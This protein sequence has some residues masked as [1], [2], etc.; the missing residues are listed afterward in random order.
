MVRSMRYLLLDQ[1]E[2][3][4]AESKGPPFQTTKDGATCLLSLNALTL[5]DLWPSRFDLSYR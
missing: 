2:L 1:R 3:L 4:L 5:V